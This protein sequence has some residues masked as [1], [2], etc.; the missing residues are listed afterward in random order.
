MSD[1]SKT[2]DTAVAGEQ[3]KFMAVMEKMTNLKRPEIVALARIYG[4]GAFFQKY[5]QR[6]IE[7][8]LGEKVAE[9]VLFILKLRAIRAES[10]ESICKTANDNSKLRDGLRSWLMDQSIGELSEKK[11]IKSPAPVAAPAS[12]PVPVTAPAAVAVNKHDGWAEI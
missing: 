3:K 6:I 2:A 4:L 9:T 8:Q 7:K 10:R 11:D 5:S 12:V 1:N